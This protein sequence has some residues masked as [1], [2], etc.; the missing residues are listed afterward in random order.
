M[1]TNAV[2]TKL[3]AGGFILGMSISFPSTTVVELAALAGF[4]LVL[5]DGEHGPIGIGDLTSMVMTAEARSI[6]SIARVPNLSPDVALRFLDT[7]VEGIL[8]PNI[9]TA[10]DARAV[11]FN[12]MYGPEGHRGLG[13][14]RKNNWG[15][16]PSPD[17]VQEANAETLALAL[18][19][20]AEGVANIDSIVETPG[21]D[22]VLLGPMD[23]AQSMGHRGDTRHPEVRRAV[24]HVVAAT[25][26]AGKAA[27]VGGGDL[28][29]ITAYRDLGANWFSVQA[30][31]LLVNGGRNFV[32]QA[33]EIL[34]A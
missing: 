1:S 22:A 7:G 12:T 28:A 6:T 16:L 17:Y 2:K 31:G 5:I 8:Y 3:S 13:L 24:E 23:L 27:G 18:I 9:S 32:E 19:E 21:I 4:D 33:S 20:S 30:T 25:R 15:G 11:V 26:R 14:V 10:E 29:A 34:S